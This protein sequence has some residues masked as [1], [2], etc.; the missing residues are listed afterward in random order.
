GIPIINSLQQDFVGDDISKVMGIMNGTTNFML[1]KMELEGADYSAVLAEAQALGYAEADPT[2]DVEGHDVQAKIA[3]LA[4]LA[5][6]QDVAVAGVPCAGISRLSAVDFANAKALGCTV[7]LLGTA[8]RVIG[9]G[10]GGK[11]GD[12]L[13]VFVSPT[14]VPLVGAL[15][16][17]RG[18]G[19][20]VVLQTKNMG[21]STYTGPGAGRY[22]TA[23]S[24]VS[25]IL[26]MAKGA[27][28]DPWPFQKEWQMD[29]DYSARFYLRFAVDGGGGS[30][31]AVEAAA[32]A[33]GVTVATVLPQD[34]AGGFVALITEVCK[35]SA[36]QAMCKALGGK[37][38]L[39]AEPLVM[40]LA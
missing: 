23:N 30:D 33:A 10:S 39:A 14:M 22:P 40:P 20:I 19:N 31:G 35:H 6:G 29:S 15:A 38:T 3:L 11:G 24:V 32:D 26:R 12:R 2:A 37:V 9:E 13:A 1:T 17:T 16:A 5:F 25:D 27:C 34:D 28:G 7:K 18:P 8:M 4:K 21:E 36:V